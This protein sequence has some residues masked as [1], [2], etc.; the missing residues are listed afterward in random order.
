MVMRPTINSMT[1]RG[2]IALLVMFALALVPAAAFAASKV[3]SQSVTR[4]GVTAT[5]SYQKGRYPDMDKNVEIS[6]AQKGVATFKQ[7]INA[8]QC[9]KQCLVQP[10][11]ALAIANLEGAAHPADVVLSLYSGGAHCCFID[12][13]YSH[14]H[15]GYTKRQADFQN[16]GARLEP[17]GPG[18]TTQFVTADNNFAYM[19]TDFAESGMPIRILSFNGLRFI[20]V[21]RSHPAMIRK[22]AASWWTA[23]RK[24]HDAGRKGLIAAWAADEYNLGQA[25]AA[26][27][28]LNAQAKKGLITRGFVSTLEQM[29][30]KYGYA[31]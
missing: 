24:D 9:H 5:V 8:L 14:G 21:T 29:L 27:A 10:K 3:M 11:H 26:R 12:E 1:R 16:S 13:V 18:G 19:F 2:R 15:S 20:N 25:K 4:D 7:Q 17:I 28:T 6:I 31:S 30:I 22:D 23:Y